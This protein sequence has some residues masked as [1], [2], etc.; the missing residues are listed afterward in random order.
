MYKLCSNVD[1]FTAIFLLG[2]SVAGGHSY[3]GLFV[4]D[5]VR[6]GIA[7][8]LWRG[9]IAAPHTSMPQFHCLTP[10]AGEYS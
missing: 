10:C 2:M 8:A 9:T 3:V 1:V 7:M 6:R 5:S 4:C